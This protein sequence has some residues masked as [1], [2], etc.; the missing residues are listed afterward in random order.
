MNERKLSRSLLQPPSG[1]YV[2]G[3]CRKLF[4]K[5]DGSRLDF[6]DETC[7]SGNDLIADMASYDTER[8]FSLTNCQSPFSPF[9]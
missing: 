9:E 3:G 2:G 7:N 8:T 4:A 6:A 5:R 1:G